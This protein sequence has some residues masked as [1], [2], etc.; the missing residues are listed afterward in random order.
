MQIV[1]F[2]VL[3]GLAGGAAV[4]LQGPMATLMSQRIG[5][6]ENILIIHVGGAIAASIPLLLA[7]GGS[8]AEWRT[9][10]WYALVAGIFGLAV[11]GALSYAIPRL[12]VGSAISLIVAGQLAVGVFLDHFGLLGAPTRPLEW[13]RVMGLLIMFVGVWLVVR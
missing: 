3:V 13:M 6:M 8:L 9:V 7:S 1:L 12:G 11:F 10:P 5:I 4:G 2:V